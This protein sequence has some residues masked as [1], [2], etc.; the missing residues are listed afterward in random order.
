MQA[1][2][3]AGHSVGVGRVG[4]SV[5]APVSRSGAPGSRKTYS[6]HLQA[7]AWEPAEI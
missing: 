2:A 6:L 7:H 3:A 5:C 4:I 1:P